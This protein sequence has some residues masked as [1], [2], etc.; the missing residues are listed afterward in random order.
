MYKNPGLSCHPWL[1]LYPHLCWYWSR[2]ILCWLGRKCIW[3]VF[4]L[5]SIVIEVPQN[6][7]SQ[8]SH[9]NSWVQDQ[10]AKQHSM[11]CHTN[12]HSKP[13]PWNTHGTRWKVSP[14]LICHKL[15][16]SPVQFLIM[17]AIISVP[18]LKNLTWTGCRVDKFACHWLLKLDLH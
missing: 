15:I 6:P 16:L 12:A 2:P 13:L 1:L 5:Q 14:A 4:L 17:C 10:C 11:L 9:F 8:L 3:L 7:K 18:W